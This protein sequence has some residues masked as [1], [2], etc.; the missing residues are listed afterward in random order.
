M[1]EKSGSL[2]SIIRKATIYAIVTGVVGG[3]I[4]LIGVWIP[5]VW[6]RIQ[7]AAA[8][9]WALLTLPILVPLAILAIL[10]LPFV[11]WIIRAARRAFAQGAPAAPQEPAGEPL[12]EVELAVLRLLAAADGRY[13]N[14][15]DAADRLHIPKL[16]LERNCEALAERGFVESNRHILYGSQIGLTRMGRD[17]VLEQGFHL[18]RSQRDW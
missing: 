17:F 16:V 10:V 13:V 18:G 6:Q 14:F 12:N 8:W 3:L 4:S 5:S 9:T 15:E 2:W 11:I 1:A 7:V